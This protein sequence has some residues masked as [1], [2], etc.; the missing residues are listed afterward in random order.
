MP[1]GSFSKVKA[2]DEIDKFLASLDV[3]LHIP[4]APNVESFGLVYIESLLAGPQCIFTKSGV[5]H[6]L[7]NISEY[8]QIV[9][10]KSV[11][12]ILSAL[13]KIKDSNVSNDYYPIA[14][15]QEYSLENM[16]KKYFSLISGSVQTP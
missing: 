3:F 7:P 4:T 2:T 13:L 11:D 15:L 10:Y 14:L 12:G 8:V 5:V 1:P 9:D 6:E 16:A